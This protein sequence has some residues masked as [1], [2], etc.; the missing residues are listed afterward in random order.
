MLP[1]P[2]L[3]YTQKREKEPE[4]RADTGSERKNEE[5]QRVEEP[6]VVPSSIARGN[7][8]L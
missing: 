8:W 7:L 5:L 1:E 6:C 3:N 2:R 4:R